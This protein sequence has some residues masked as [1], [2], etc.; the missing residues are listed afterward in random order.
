MRDDW[1]LVEIKE[2]PLVARLLFPAIVLTD[3]EPGTGYVRRDKHF[4]VLP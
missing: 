1:G 3:R 2:I 4:K